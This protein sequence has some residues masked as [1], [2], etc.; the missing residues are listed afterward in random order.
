MVSF[1]VTYTLT[2]D[3]LTNTYSVTRENPDLI[4]PSSLEELEEEIKKL[5]K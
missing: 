3:R 5:R 4:E 1:T 2:I